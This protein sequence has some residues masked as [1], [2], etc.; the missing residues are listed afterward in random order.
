M[1]ENK[2]QFMNKSSPAIERILI[3]AK[4]A[5]H[6]LGIRRRTLHRLRHKY[7]T[8]PTPIKDGPHLQAHVYFVKT[9]LEVWIKSKADSRLP[10]PAIRDAS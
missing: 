6:M 7:P 2:R 8:F 5:M 3:S 10:P 1:V 9:E 4:D